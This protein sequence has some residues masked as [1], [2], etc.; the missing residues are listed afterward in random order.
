MSCVHVGKGVRW[1]SQVRVSCFAVYGPVRAS[2]PPRRLLARNNYYGRPSPVRTAE[3]QEAASELGLYLRHMASNFRA[4]DDL[5]SRPQ[6]PDKPESP[7]HFGVRDREKELKLGRG[8]EFRTYVTRG[9]RPF[10]FNPGLRSPPLELTKP[11]TY[12][13][14]TK[15]TTMSAGTDIVRRHK[16]HCSCAY[17]RDG[18]RIPASRF[19]DHVSEAWSERR[20]TRTRKSHWQAARPANTPPRIRGW[21]QRKRFESLPSA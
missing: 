2:S 17:L 15:D 10:R 5:T 19:A 3:A 1:C 4:I 8:I 6:R 21:A 13:E 16:D 12:P 14:I 9:R 7:A 11:W 18:R 20:P